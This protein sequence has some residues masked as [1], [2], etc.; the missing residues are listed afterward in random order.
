MHLCD[1]VFSLPGSLAL[2][3]THISPPLGPSCGHKEFQDLESRVQ[4]VLIMA[5]WGRRR[6]HSTQRHPPPTPQSGWGSPKFGKS[7]DR[8]FQSAGSWQLVT[9]EG[10]LQEH[11]CI[12]SVFTCWHKV[13]SPYSTA[14]AQV[15]LW[16][17]VC[18][19]LGLDR[20][21]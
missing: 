1:P 11:C 16:V 6:T 17:I 9:R 8:P 10:P 18:T 21:P 4:L 20:L 13:N 15:R 2:P 7:T 3:F 19:H 14:L 5:T 12:Q